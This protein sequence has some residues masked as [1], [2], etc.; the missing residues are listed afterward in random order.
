MVPMPDNLADP[1]LNGFSAA[2]LVIGLLVGLAMMVLALNSP[3]PPE[4]T[5]D[6]PTTIQFIP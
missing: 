4:P 2:L 1:E 5:T 6:P 3:A